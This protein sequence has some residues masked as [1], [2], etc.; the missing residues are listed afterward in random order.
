MRR[1]GKGAGHT[2]DPNKFSSAAPCPRVGREPEPGRKRVGIAAKTG[3]NALM[4]R[5]Q[6]EKS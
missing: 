1:V 2:A 5:A 6:N 3:V 4:S